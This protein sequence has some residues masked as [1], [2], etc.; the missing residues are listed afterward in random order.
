MNIQTI[1]IIHPNG[2]QI[3]LINDSNRHN[4]VIMKHKISKNNDMVQNVI[5]I[6]SPNEIE[7]TQTVI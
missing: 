6:D 4:I 3:I 1:A 5:M 7:G 2:G